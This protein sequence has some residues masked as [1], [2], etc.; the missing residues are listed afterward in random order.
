M[1][2]IETR[3]VD[4]VWKIVTGRDVFPRVCDDN[5]I[6]KSLDELKAIVTGL[7]EN[8]LNHTVLVQDDEGV[9][10]GCFV[11][12]AK[13]GGNLEEHTFMSAACR[14]WD[15][16][17]AGKRAMKLLFTLPDVEKLTSYCPACL[18]ESYWFARRCGWHNAGF[19]E[20]RWL[21]NGI[22]HLVTLVEV[23]REDFACQ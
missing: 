3:D 18:P 6:H 17:I 15:A 2:V 1:N 8:P 4:A 16:I 13:G 10:I 23:N 14:G 20:W 5:W 21:K 19:A 11:G 9:P 12:I 22:E 7:V